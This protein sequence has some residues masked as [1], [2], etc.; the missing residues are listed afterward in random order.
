MLRNALDVDN[1]NLFVLGTILKLMKLLMKPAA[2]A[3]NADTAW[4]YALPRL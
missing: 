3:L 1:A 4:R 2:T